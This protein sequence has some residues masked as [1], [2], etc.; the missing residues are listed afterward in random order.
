MLHAR[1]TRNQLGDNNMSKT[2]L[3]QVYDTESQ[4]VIGPVVAERRDAPA[5]RVFH[6]LLA[7]P[8]TILGKYPNQFSL[9]YL[10][11][12]DLDTALITPEQLPTAIATGREWLAGKQQTPV[13]VDQ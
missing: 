6:E 8:E 7:N 10:G 2:K 13:R 12:Q 1:N 5:I 3:Y 9:L 11:E 4:T